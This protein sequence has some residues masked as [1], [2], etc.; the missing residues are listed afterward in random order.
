MKH[1]SRQLLVGSIALGGILLLMLLLTNAKAR[2]D[3]EIV[4]TFYAGMVLLGSEVKSLRGKHGKIT[5]SFVRVSPTGA[6]LINANFPAYRY[7]P[8]PEY[9]PMRSR[10]LLLRSGELLRWQ[11]KTQNK[12]LTLIPLAV[13]TKGR[14]IKLLVGVGKGRTHGDKRQH[15]KEREL[16]RELARHQR[17]YG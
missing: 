3:Y 14:F 13:E 9:N 4:E 7:S 17:R 11:E 6:V 16:K 5:G 1:N 10:R 12:G 2:F 15:I 8:N